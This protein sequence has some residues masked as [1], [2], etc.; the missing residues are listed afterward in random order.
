MGCH[1]E[2][3]KDQQSLVH[4]H[5]GRV[6]LGNK[7]IPRR[8]GAKRTKRGEAAQS[9]RLGTGLRADSEDKGNFIK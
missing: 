2:G 5:M 4:V 9:L 8:D 7:G 6:Q 3:V 1:R